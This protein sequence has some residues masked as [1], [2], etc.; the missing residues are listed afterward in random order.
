MDAPPRDPPSNP[1]KKQN[2][3]LVHSLAKSLR[4]L[5]S[6]WTVV[7]IIVAIILLVAYF[8]L[9]T[10]LSCAVTDY[11]ADTDADGNIAVNVTIKNFGVREQAVLVRTVVDLQN[12]TFQKRYQGYDVVTL[13]PGEERTVHIITETG[14][15]PPVPQV[16]KAYAFV[17]PSH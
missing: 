15:E 17:L 7:A 9:T 8:F 6:P 5:R 1:P 2:G 14:L 13:G 12:E 10:P 16:K 3:G 11:T 4:K